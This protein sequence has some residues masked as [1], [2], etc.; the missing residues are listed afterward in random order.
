MMFPPKPPSVMVQSNSGADV[1]MSRLEIESEIACI[2][3]LISAI[4]ASMAVSEAAAEISKAKNKKQFE[5]TKVSKKNKLE[6]GD[7]KKNAG[8]KNRKNGKL[9]QDMK[10]MKNI[11]ENTKK[12]KRGQEVEVYEGGKH[13][14][15]CIPSFL[16]Q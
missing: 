12:K 10:Q 7:T 2:E 8:G 3:D 14:G 4:D 1:L 5:T 13:S 16:R 6:D 9:E 11:K 15:Y